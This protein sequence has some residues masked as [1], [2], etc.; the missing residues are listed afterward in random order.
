MR[1]AEWSGFGS[2]R[3]GLRRWSGQ[4]SLHQQN[5]TYRVFG[6]ETKPIWLSGVRR[7]H[8]DTATAM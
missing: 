5:R 8:L 6:K 3:L 7:A 4:V 1:S 2:S